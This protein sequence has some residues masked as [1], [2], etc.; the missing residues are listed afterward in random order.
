MSRIR[1]ESTIGERFSRLVVIGVEKINGRTYMKCEC[2]CGNIPLIWY[3]HLR[4]GA[5]KSCGCLNLEK[6]RD[7]S[8][9]HGMSE[10]QT[11]KIWYGMIKRCKKEGNKSFASYG[12]RGIFVCERWHCFENFLS[13]MGERPGENYSLDRIDNERGYCKENCRWAT[14]KQ[15]ANN[16]RNNINVFYDGKSMTVA[17]LSSI[18]GV[19]Y[20]LL[21]WRLKNNWTVSDAVSIPVGAKRNG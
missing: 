10:T 12:G 13:D 11:Y 3:G 5:T 21:R 17:E 9:K 6:I 1:A 16:K 7:R 18:S 15:Q 19:G 8:T 4:T 20:G 2:D 14:R